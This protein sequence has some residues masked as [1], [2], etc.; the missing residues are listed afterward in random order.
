MDH[1]DPATW[2]NLDARLN[3][4]LATRSCPYAILL[5]LG[6]SHGIGHQLGTFGVGH[7]ETSCILMPAVLKYNWKHGDENVREKQ[8]R[9][10]KVFWSEPT[11][12]EL[13]KAKG[14]SE[15]TADTGI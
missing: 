10:R 1:V 14:L 15:H 7:G 9:I 3:Q 5:S 13:L 4:M 8:R 12:V 2:N 6:P 11:V